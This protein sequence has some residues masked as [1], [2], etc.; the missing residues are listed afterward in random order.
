MDRL[1]SNVNL[2]LPAGHGLHGAVD[3]HSLVAVAVAAEDEGDVQG[4]AIGQGLLHAIAQA[5]AV[6]LGLDHRDGLVLLVA[7]YVIGASLLTAGVQT[8]ADDDA[9][10]GEG[11]LF[12]NLGLEVPARLNQRRRDELAA[13]IP[14]AELLLIHQ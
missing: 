4:I 6:V 10:R 11:D 5:V 12:A 7:Q 3:G 14:F 8:A 1:P 13:N 2:I 9:A